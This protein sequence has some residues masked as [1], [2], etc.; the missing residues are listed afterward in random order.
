[1]SGVVFQ[2]GWWLWALVLVPVAALAAALWWVRTRRA[3]GLWTGR[4]IPTPAPAGVRIARV[5]IAV[6]LLG[7]LAAAIVAM[8]RPSRVATEQESRST[9]MLTVDVSASMNRTD[10]APNRL[11]AAVTAANRFVDQAPEHTAIGLVT[12]ARGARVVV[13]PTRDR[14]RMR[15]ALADLETIRG[16]TALGEAIVTALAAL[17]ADGAVNADHPD[18]AHAPGRI[19]LLTDGVDTARL[20]T[21]PEQAAERAA[22][23][24]VPIYAILLGNDPGE[25]GAA[26]PAETLSAMA[27]RTGGVFAQSATSADLTRVFGD[28]GSIVAPVERLRELTVWSALAALALLVAA[29]TVGVFASFDADARKTS[30]ARNS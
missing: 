1:M 7:A 20:A 23:A 30:P 18:P 9:V 13:A 10:L 11:A 14:D 19:L 17:Q 16:H 26:T 21:S 6:L 12:F 4:A 28:I 3:G 15:S 27:T 25:P 8:A 2:D 22:V 29:L 5:V 24:G